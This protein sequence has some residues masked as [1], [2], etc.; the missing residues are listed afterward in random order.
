MSYDGVSLEWCGQKLIAV[1]FGMNK[2]G[3]RKGMEMGFVD[4]FFKKFN[5]K[6][7]RN[8]NSNWKRNVDTQS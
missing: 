6:R 5:Y 4:N 8:I 3:K 7:E 2:K 1:G